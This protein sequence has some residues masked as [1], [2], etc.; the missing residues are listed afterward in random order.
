MEL[1]DTLETLDKLM[2][3]MLP[4]A[5]GTDHASNRSFEERG[6]GGRQADGRAHLLEPTNRMV[7]VWRGM[8]PSKALLNQNGWRAWGSL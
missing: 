3:G 2:L 6:M 8:V 7:L 1:Q 5:P 4:V